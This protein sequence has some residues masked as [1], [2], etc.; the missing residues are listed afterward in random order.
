LRPEPAG[1][2]PRPRASADQESDPPFRNFA[3]P[4]EK[5]PGP[6]LHVGGAFL[7]FPEGDGF[8]LVDQHALH[9]RILFEELMQGL[10]G[11]PRVPAQRLL[12]PALFEA[13][14]ADK[15]ALLEARESLARLGFHI[16]DFGPGTIAVEALAAALAGAD[17]ADLMEEILASLAAGGPAGSRSLEER[18]ASAAC[19]AAVKSGERL[20]PH[21]VAELLER[22]AAADHPG[23]CPHGRPTAVH[24]A[25]KDLER[26]FRRTGPA[27]GR[28]LPE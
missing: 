10:Q 14:A 1:P 8:T 23:H 20:T 18:I 24:F 17:A 6:H 22:A 5:R 7:L 19:R 15:A 26:L 4:A 16:A 3:P 13:G 9:E 25:R 27:G 11:Q 21:Q 2:A 28:D 12:V